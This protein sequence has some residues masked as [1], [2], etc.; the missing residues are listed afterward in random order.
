M[1]DIHQSKQNLWSGDLETQY[2]IHFKEPSQHS[3]ITFTFCIDV[4]RLPLS[5]R[6]SLLLPFCAVF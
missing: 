2:L 6:H 1:P 3:Q 5:L 4:V